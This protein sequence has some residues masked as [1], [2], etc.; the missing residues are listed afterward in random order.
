MSEQKTPERSLPLTLLAVFILCAAFIHANSPELERREIPPDFKE[1]LCVNLGPDCFAA[2]YRYRKAAYPFDW[3][4]TLDSERFLE[5]LEDDFKHYL[6]PTYYSTHTNGAIIHTYYHLE[7]RH[8]HDHEFYAKYKRRIERFRALA[9]YQGKVVFLR[10]G[11]G[12]AEEPS[13][14]WPNRE[15]LVISSE[16]AFKLNAILKKKFPSLDY[17]LGILNYPEDENYYFQIFDRLVF[18]ELDGDVH[19]LME[20]MVDTM[21]SCN[22]YPQGVPIPVDVLPKPHVRDLRKLSY[23]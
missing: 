9:D 1:V 11:Y 7:F 8:E 22:G 6:D 17:Y 18:F 10:R 13:F 4:L 12:G 19:D 14:Y 15:A 5:I 21:A 16:W 20:F 2:G 3:V 23:Q